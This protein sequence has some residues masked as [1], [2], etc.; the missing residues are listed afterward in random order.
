MDEIDPKRPSRLKKFK[1]KNN[2]GFENLMCNAKTT[3]KEL[4]NLR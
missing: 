3:V 4:V 2:S 1:P